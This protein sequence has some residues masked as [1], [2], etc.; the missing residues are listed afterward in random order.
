MSNLGGG[1]GGRGPWGRGGAPHPQ[2][3]AGWGPVGGPQGR[4]G[5][6]G[7]G[8]GPHG[9]GGGA[10]RGGGPHPQAAGG[11]QGGPWGRGVG[12]RGRGAPF[13]SEPHATHL[14]DQHNLRFRLPVQHTVEDLQDFEIPAQLTPAVLQ[15]YSNQKRAYDLQNYRFTIDVFPPGQ[16]A[17]SVPVAPAINPIVEENCFLLVQIRDDESLFRILIEESTG[18]SVAF[19]EL[20][21]SDL[22]KSIVPWFQF[23]G[24]IDLP[25]K[26]FPI[27]LIQY[28]VK[29]SA[30]EL[31]VTFAEGTGPSLCNFLKSFRGNPQQP[32]TVEG[33]KQFDTLFVLIN[34]VFRWSSIERWARQY[35]ILGADRSRLIRN[36]SNLS[37][38]VFL[39]VLYLMEESMA[40]ANM[41]DRN[42]RR[43]ADESALKARRRLARLQYRLQDYGIDLIPTRVQGFQEDEPIFE[44]EN[45]QLDHIVLNEELLSRLTGGDNSFL[46]LLKHNQVR[47]DRILY[48]MVGYRGYL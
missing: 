6:A 26:F 18:Y 27:V 39:L 20:R 14:V 42:L 1:G 22:D 19:Q 25:V 23:K 36:Y 41:L 9:G 2:A 28:D 10:G 21:D 33:K 43:F 44:D 31:D 15:A 11:R 32:V 46:K 4:G 38:M 7:H 35:G 37:E 40:N 29:Y 47:C 13:L 16:P 3:A 24:T 5:G 34:E 45:F 17:V 48:R 30:G 12:G 8:G